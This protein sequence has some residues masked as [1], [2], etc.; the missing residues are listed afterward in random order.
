M[1]NPSVAVLIPCIDR[2]RLLKKSLWTLSRQTVACDVFIIDDGSRPGLAEIADDYGVHYE[3]LREP[4][5]PEAYDTRGPS[6]AWRHGF[7]MT[8]HDFVILSMPEILVPTD[9]VERML[10]G[11]QSPR[12]STP[13]LQFINRPLYK[14]MDTVDWRADVHVLQTLPEFATVH[15]RWGFFNFN[16]HE[17]AHH[18]CFTGQTRD[19]WLIHDFMPAGC[20]DDAWLHPVEDTLTRATGVNHR[21]HFVDLTVYH[22]FHEASPQSALQNDLWH[23]QNFG[24]PIPP[25]GPCSPRIAQIRKSERKID[26]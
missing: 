9:A 8:D 16:M 7:L 18:I 2:H 6:H 11:H 26:D 19:D 1:S 15:N 4:L 25:S 20:S 24:G 21:V 10:D 14:L 23:E 13:L 12:R 22:L 3:Q 17:W 5:L